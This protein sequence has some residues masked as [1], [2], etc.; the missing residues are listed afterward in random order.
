[1]QETLLSSHYA[2][3]VACAG[4]LLLF[5]APSQPSAVCLHELATKLSLGQSGRNIELMNVS[6]C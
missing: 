1:M 4:R 3:A 5:P 2:G 6:I